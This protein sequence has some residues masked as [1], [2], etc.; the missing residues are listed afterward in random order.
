LAPI[1]RPVR[2]ISVYRGATV[3]EDG[4]LYSFQPPNFPRDNEGKDTTP[5]SV[6]VG[7]LRDSYRLARAR[8]LERAKLEE[9]SDVLFERGV[10]ADHGNS[11]RIDTTQGTPSMAPSQ[12]GPLMRKDGGWFFVSPRPLLVMRGQ[13]DSAH[14][15]RRR[16]RPCDAT[17]IRFAWR[18]KPDAEVFDTRC[19]RTPRRPEDPKDSINS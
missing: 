15:P 7:S 5:S 14:A 16:R 19:S 6:K 2:H 18:G 9:W 1:A 10:K 4:N 13:L 11:L 17:P 3:K 12:G 8:H